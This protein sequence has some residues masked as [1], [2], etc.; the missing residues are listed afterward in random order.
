MTF[1][2]GYQMDIVYYTFCVS[3]FFL[4]AL[5]QMEIPQE[6][7]S[8]IQPLPKRIQPG[9]QRFQVKLYEAPMCMVL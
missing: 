8:A 6:M 2:D 1:G 7:Q 4:Q 5:T 9:Y 3:F